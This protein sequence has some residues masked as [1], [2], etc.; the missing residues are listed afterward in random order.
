VPTKEYDPKVLHKSYGMRGTNVIGK[1]K[2]VAKKPAKKAAK[3]VA[4][5]PAKKAA[6]K[7]AKKR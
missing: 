4:K 6:K 5:K 3:K 1:P 7:T 2:K